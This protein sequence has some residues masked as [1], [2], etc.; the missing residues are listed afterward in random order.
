MTEKLSKEMLAAI[1]QEVIKIEGK[2]KKERKKQRRNR[3]LRNTRLLLENYQMLREHC[4]GIVPTLHNF[5][6]SLF[7]PEELNI[8][9]LMKY[10]AR[11]KEMLD[12]FDVMFSSYSQYCHNKGTSAERRFNVIRQLYVYE[13]SGQ[14]LNK[15]NLAIFY[16][17]DTRTI[18]R[19]VKK[20]SEEL[21]VFLYG[22]D[23][24]DDLAHVLSAT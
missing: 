14:H 1:T 2:K 4:E 13:N 19:D 5:E 17:V 20:A 7:D 6:N 15:T 24:L 18:N 3:K 10:K 8:E 23:S 16:N 11:T 22:I 21:S 9:I 12:Y